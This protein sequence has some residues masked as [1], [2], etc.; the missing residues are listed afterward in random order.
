MDFQRL[1][2]SVAKFRKWNNAMC[3]RDH[4]ESGPALQS[5]LDGLAGMK[6]THFLHLG[7]PLLRHTWKDA[8]AGVCVR[9]RV[10]QGSGACLVPSMGNGQA[11]CGP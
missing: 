2:K 7:K 5:K 9:L 11:E 4:G 1:D 10:Q 3:W 8:H 6:Q